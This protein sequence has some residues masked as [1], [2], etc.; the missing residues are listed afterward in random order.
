VVRETKVWSERIEFVNVGH[1]DAEKL[2]I[3]P[4]IVIG[5]DIGFLR[6]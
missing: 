6:H 5:D 1:G 4:T 2:P 3:G